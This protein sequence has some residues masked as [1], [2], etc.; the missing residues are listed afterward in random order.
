M[1]KIYLYSL[2]SVIKSAFTNQL[3]RGRSMS[4]SNNSVLIEERRDEIRE[5]IMPN[6]VYFKVMQYANE[7][8]RLTEEDDWDNCSLREIAVRS[9][10]RQERET[11]K[12]EERERQYYERQEIERQKWIEERMKKLEEEKQRLKEAGRKV[13]LEHEQM[14]EAKAVEE[15]VAK[16]PV[17]AEPKPEGVVQTVMIKTH[18]GGQEVRADSFEALTC[19]FGDISDLLKSMGDIALDSGDQ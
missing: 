14:I 19:T 3:S 16:Q 6:E 13:L 4:K 17:E 5:N 8:V 11:R 12:E 7:A 10:E 9:K 15:K 2:I 1:T 18:H